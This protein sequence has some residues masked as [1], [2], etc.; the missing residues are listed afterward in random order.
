MKKIFIAGINHVDARS[1]FV[2]RY[3]TWIGVSI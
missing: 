2:V 1:E 3:I